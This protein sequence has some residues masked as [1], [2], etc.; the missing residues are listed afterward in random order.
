MINYIIKFFKTHWQAKIVSV[1]IAIL[2][3]YY[4][5]YTKTIKKT[6]YIKVEP[7]VLPHYLTFSEELPAF[8]KVDFYGP[9]EIM[10]IE[11]TNFKLHLIN[12]G[13]NPGKN[14]FRLDLIPPPPSGIQSVIEF[15]EIEIM[16]DTKKRKSLPLIPNYI[17]EGNKKVA[18]WNFKP[19]SLTVEGPEKVFSKLDRIFLKRIVLP[20]NS[21]I[22]FD[23][24]LLD[25]LPKFVK[26]VENQPFEIPLEIKYFSEEELAEKKN[27]LSEEF[28]VFEEELE[29]NCK[30]LPDKVELENF[31]K[32]KVT[33][34][35][36]IELNKNFFKAES[37]CPIEFN[38]NLQS[39]E[40]STII[41][42]LPVQ[43]RLI[44]E[45]KDIEILKV[46][47]ILVDFQFKIRKKQFYNQKEKGL[48][49]HLIR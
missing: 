47:P 27:S 11:Q 49:E 28:K 12:T 41:S 10:N 23:K 24:V 21:N 36:R 9:E 5:Q 20:K 4:V 18:Y 37:F 7:P 30:E 39:I 17:L 48:Q 38:A 43:V 32:V 26:L 45:I 29:V 42:K 3:S 16:V 33:Y 31:P 44:Q 35:S 34:I 2:F 1:I 22:F 46:D 19:N 25:E 8:I 15:P 14:K 6:F 13:P 40:P